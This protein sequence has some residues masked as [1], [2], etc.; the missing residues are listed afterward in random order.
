MVSQ[1]LAYA[2]LGMIMITSLLLLLGQ[3]KRY[4]FVGYT[5]QYLGVFFLIVQVWP[6]GLALIKLIAG[7][8][9]VAILTATLFNQKDDEEVDQSVS[10]TVFKILLG[11][12]IW[13]LIF[14]VSPSIIRWLPIPYVFLWS[15]LILF[16]V[17]LLQLAIS[18]STYRVIF[19]LLTT[20]SGFEILYAV[21]E[22]S[23]L[24]TLLLAVVNLGLAIVGAYILNISRVEKSE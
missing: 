24:V 23:T 21:V 19:G 17:G 20:F 18:N 22:N 16:G 10:S 2:G 9:S 12:L 15:G 5:V 14:T 8:M 6:P 7:W 11:V 13:V 1:I 4:G 3:N